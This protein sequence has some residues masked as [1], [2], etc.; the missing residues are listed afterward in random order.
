MHNLCAHDFITAVAQK[1]N[2]ALHWSC[3]RNFLEMFIFLLARGGDYS[4]LNDVSYFFV[5]AIPVMF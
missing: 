5:F 3:R 4:A 2:S 1:R